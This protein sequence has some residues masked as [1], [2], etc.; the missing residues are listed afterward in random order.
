MLRRFLPSL[1]KK[2]GKKMNE[3][4]NQLKAIINEIAG[5]EQLY[6]CTIPLIYSS[7][8]HCSKFFA[9]HHTEYTS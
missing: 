1:K 8:D 5:E 9:T 4:N 7:L 2:E 6:K 3:K